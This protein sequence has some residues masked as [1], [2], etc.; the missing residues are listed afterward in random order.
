[1]TNPLFHIARVLHVPLLFLSYAILAAA[2]TVGIIYI[3]QER[4][5]KSKH[6]GE[7]AYEL[8]SLM[9]LDA[10]IFKL[11]LVAFPLLTVGI[12]LGSIWAHQSS[13]RFWSWDPSETWALITWLVYVA[14]LSARMGAG[15][16]GRKTTYLSLAGFALVLVT[17]VGV[18]YF[19]PLHGLLIG[20]GHR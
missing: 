14:Y 15:W 4:Q 9:A 17:Y 1:M 18:N 10:L 7:L 11:I 8:P 16:R 13:G 12:F 19:S 5:M 2:F 3:W 6:L 20:M